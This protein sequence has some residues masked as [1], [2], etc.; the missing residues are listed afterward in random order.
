MRGI[1]V[2]G[3]IQECVG[4]ILQALH[5]LMQAISLGSQIGRD[6]F[7]IHLLSNALNESILARAEAPLREPHGACAWSPRSPRHSLARY[8]A[9]VR[10]EVAN[11]APIS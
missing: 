1:E 4:L 6:L 11:S 2:V 10:C 8:P 3:H 9:R 7:L 5:L